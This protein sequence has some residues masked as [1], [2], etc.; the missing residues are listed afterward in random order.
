LIGSAARHL[1]RFIMTVDDRGVLKRPF[2]VLVG[3]T[4]VA[5]SAC[6][7]TTSPSPSNPVVSLSASART[8]TFLCRL[9]ATT[10]VEHDRL[11][12]ALSAAD[13]GDQP[14]AATEARVAFKNVSDAMS[15]RPPV[16]MPSSDDASIVLMLAWPDVALAEM[17]LAS[18]IAPDVRPLTIPAVEAH[19]A[20]T[21]L[22]RAI[23]AARTTSRQ[24]DPN[25]SLCSAPW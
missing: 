25:G 5:L 24:Q 18:A 1:R 15:N 14:T 7:A 6:N 12:H 4:L 21:S 10:T 20:L 2:L 9:V 19:A 8:D 17:T 11:V 22:D 13:Q 16:P 23:E 3:A